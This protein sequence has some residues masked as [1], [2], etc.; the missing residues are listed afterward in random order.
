[1][2]GQPFLQLLLVVV[3]FA[4]VG[5]PVWRL[6][7]P[8]ATAANNAA[9]VALTPDARKE[10]LAEIELTVTAD[11]VP[12]PEEVH[13]QFLGRDLLTGRGPRGEWTGTW[14]TVLPAEGADLALRARWPAGAAD[15][16]AP[17]AAAHV[18][19][20]FPDDRPPVERT[21]WAPHGGSLTELVVVP[22]PTTAAP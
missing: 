9:S 2:R 8:V 12:A 22:G 19:V 4:V 5:W 13:L 1:M 6:T 16:A 11:F 14:K 18:V 21:F 15:N 7:R 3:A 20:R 10:G 17:T